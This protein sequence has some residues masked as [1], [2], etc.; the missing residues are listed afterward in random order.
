MR[1]IY[2][3]LFLALVLLVLFSNQSDWDYFYSVF[4]VEYRSW[5]LDRRPPLWSYQFCAGVTRI[6]DPQSMGLSP[7]FLPVLL[8]GSFWGAKA[9]V[10]L[11]C[12][13]GIFYL[14][15]LL[16]QV[17]RGEREVA[18]SLAF[19][20][21]F[22]NYYLWHL[23]VGHVSF[24]LQ[25][26]ALMPASLTL[27][28]LQRK[29][30]R[31]ELFL[32]FFSGFSYCTAGFYHASVFFLL[33]LA[34]IFAVLL[35]RF[36]PGWPRRSLLLPVLV[37]NGAALLLSA[38]RWI[39]ALAYQNQFPRSLGS[40]AEPN[41]AHWLLARLTLPTLGQKFLDGNP[42]WGPWLMHEHSAFS[43][44][45]WLVV[46]VLISAYFLR[47]RMDWR[48]A[49]GAELFFCFLVTSLFCGNSV[50]SPV[51]WINRYLMAGSLRAVGRFQVV[52]VFLLALFLMRFLAVHPAARA[53]YLRYL[54]PLGLAI[55]AVTLLTFLPWLDLQVGPPPASADASLSS[56]RRVP[57][58]DLSAVAHSY[59]Y[60]ALRAGEIVPNCYQPLARETKVEHELWA[61]PVL[62]KGAS[63]S[64]VAEGVSEACGRSVRITQNE[65]EFD[66]GL[67][68]EI[69]LRL[70][71]L[72][73]YRPEKLIWNPQR[74]L[75]CR[76]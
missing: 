56:A 61:S 7:L 5:I 48:R 73:L 40:L 3:L 41:P 18:L 42:D 10:I 11:C 70:N 65:I 22:G 68:P 37:M 33:P 72:N 51:H 8:L 53:F 34:G 66:E 19:F 16:E 46:G 44:L 43:V 74:G 28:G 29:L 55:V 31:R 54:R 17:G 45:P 13:I 50:I 12:A 75:F 36:R 15:R 38:Y 20:F 1:W 26:F 63:Y 39:P 21:V 25:L 4:E 23:H 47:E 58:R 9:L 27:Q 67:C 2:S 64:V 69:C 14:T 32:L 62:P 59:M 6:G 71:M 24:A 35:L 60:P 57:A 30:S 49:W 52:L 76:P